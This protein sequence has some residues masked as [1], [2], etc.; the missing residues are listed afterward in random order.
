MQKCMCAK[1]PKKYVRATM[2]Q[3]CAKAFQKSTMHW[4]L[5]FLR[6]EIF[7]LTIVS[8][9]ENERFMKA[10]DEKFRKL[11]F[12]FCRTPKAYQRINSHRPKLLLFSMTDFVTSFFMSYINHWGSQSKRLTKL[13]HN[14]HFLSG[15]RINRSSKIQYCSAMKKMFSLW[16]LEFEKQQ[17]ICQ[18][19]AHK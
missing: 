12:F 15:Y 16:W 2:S 7:T 19:E 13:H 14:L 17:L 9:E 11:F 10:N 4:S 1:A 18:F 5:K 8:N 3:H 6:A